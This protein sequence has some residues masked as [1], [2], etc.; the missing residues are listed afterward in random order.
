MGEDPAGELDEYEFVDSYSSLALVSSEL[1][2]ETLRFVRMIEFLKDGNL[3]K[4][5]KGRDESKFS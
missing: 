5:F 4:T 3:A 1:E 2:E